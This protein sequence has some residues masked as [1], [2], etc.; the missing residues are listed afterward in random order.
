MK[1]LLAVLALSI[2]LTAQGWQ[3]VRIVGIAEYPLLARH[4][5]IAGRV[6]LRCVSNLETGPP[7]CSV[8]SGHKVLGQA[9]KSNAEQWRFR[10]ADGSSARVDLIYD[11]KLTT[12]VQNV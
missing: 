2:C 11:F 10:D 12:P 7:I 9:A 4:A 8:I 6:H 5:G 3:A 1:T